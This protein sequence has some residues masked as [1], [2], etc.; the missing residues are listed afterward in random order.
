MGAQTAALLRVLLLSKLATTGLA[1]A[2]TAAPTVSLMP[3]AACG[4]GEAFNNESLTCEPCSAGKF[5]N[6]TGPTSCIGCAAGTYRVYSTDASEAIVCY[7]C[8]NGRVSSS[9]KSECEECE[10]GQYTVNGTYCVECPAGLYA[11]TPQKDECV[12][13]EAG[14][15]T[16]VATGAESCESCDAGTYAPALSTNCTTCLAGTYSGSRAEKCTDC[17]PGK[18][19]ATNQ[20]TACTSCEVGKFNNESVAKRCYSC[21]QGTFQSSTGQTYCKDCEA[22]KYSDDIEVSSCTSCDAGRYSGAG[23]KNCTYCADGFF[24][25]SGQELCFACE[26]GRYSSVDTGYSCASCEAGKYAENS[27]S[28]DCKKCPAGTKSTTAASICTD[29]L[30]DYYQPDVGQD[31]C[32]KCSTEIGDGY[33]AP[34]GST[35]CSRCE[36]GYYMNAAGTCVSCPS[37][38]AVDCTDEGNELEHLKVK[39]GYFRFTPTSTS[40]YKCKYDGVCLATNQTTNDFQCA[41][42]SYGP[43]CAN[44]EQNMYLDTGKEKCVECSDVGASGDLAAFST[45]VVVLVLAVAIYFVW[46]Q[47]TLDEMRADAES[48]GIELTT[49]GELRRWSMERESAANAANCGADQSTT[50]GESPLYI[51]VLKFATTTQT[52]LIL[53]SN[54]ELVGGRAAPD[55]LDGYTDI[56]SWIKLDTSWVPGF[57]CVVLGFEYDLIAQTICFLTIL[58]AGVVY[59]KIRKLF[60]D[61]WAW[62][63]LEQ[64]VLFSHFFLPVVSSTIFYTFRCVNY[65]GGDFR[66]MLADYTISCTSDKFSWLTAYAAVMVAI[67]PIGMPLFALFY[68]RQIKEQLVQVEIGGYRTH[69]ELSKDPM[70]SLFDSYEPL[71]APWYDVYDMGRRLVLTGGTLVVTQLSTFSLLAVCV[72]CFALSLNEHAKP[73]VLDFEDDLASAELWLIL[74]LCLVFIVGDAEMFDTETEYEIAGVCIMSLNLFMIAIIFWSSLPSYNDIKTGAFRRRMINQATAATKRTYSQLGKNCG[75]VKRYAAKSVDRRSTATAAPP[76]SEAAAHANEPAS[77]ADVVNAPGVGATV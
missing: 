38:S 21:G 70:R 55:I 14:F 53:N 51:G 9:D 1:I 47:A 36:A 17:S 50:Q 5:K 15:A 64:L 59:W 60:N 54:H 10:G 13:C 57:S 68:L 75:R 69:H 18:F 34:K 30:E 46:R 23:A 8:P 39:A 11:P 35:N 45:G 67:I 41:D 7:D 74:L 31:E 12:V 62:H 42:G 58:A 26:A 65:D 73:Y 66:Y 37:S 40:V 49:W 52:L 76:P 32:L 28:S 63:T 19:A 29:C 61:P 24:S 44:C 25:N 2:P 48:E 20:S 27:N 77:L 4:V 33:G 43:L 6:F 16:T 22:G 3:T 56:W 72:S 71:Y